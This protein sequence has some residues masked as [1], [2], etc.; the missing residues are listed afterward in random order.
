[1]KQKV[2]SS[3]GGCLLLA[4]LLFVCPIR[5]RAADMIKVTEDDN[6]VQV[7]YELT[8][9][10][11]EEEST[12]AVYR[13]EISFADEDAKPTELNIKSKVTDTEGNVYRI[14]EITDVAYKQ[15]IQTITMQDGI[16]S[17]Y[18][19]ALAAYNEETSSIKE[20]KFPST[21]E[22][23][24]GEDGFV[25]WDNH[26]DTVVVPK[27]LKN[28]T[29]DNGVVY[30]GKVAIYVPQAGNDADKPEEITLKEGCVKIAHKALFGN[31]AVKKV[32][33]PASVKTIGGAAFDGCSNLSEVNFAANAQLEDIDWRAFYDCTALTAVKIPDSVTRIGTETFSGCTS[34][35]KADISEK[36][37]LTLIEYGAFGYYP[38]EVD[39]QEGVGAYLRNLEP[40][41]GYTS[42]KNAGTKIK[43]IYLP[44]ATLH[45]YSNNFSAAGLF[46][47]CTTLEKVTIGNSGDVKAELPMEMFAGCTALKELYMNGNVK[48][49]GTGAFVDCANL[50]SVNLTGTEELKPYSFV[51]TGITEVTI[52]SSVKKVGQFSF[53]ACTELTTMNLRSSLPQQDS[54]VYLNQIIGGRWSVSQSDSTKYSGYEAVKK[55][56]PKRTAL[57]KLN[58]YMD[59][60]TGKTAIDGRNMFATALY[61]LEEVTLPEGM[62]EIPENAFSFCFSLK[63]ADF[64]ASIQK[65]GKWAF[66][67]DLNLDVDFS[68]LTNLETIEERA[69]MLQGNEGQA[70]MKEIVLPN[71]LKSIG[72]SAFY[73]Q[74]KATKVVIPESV[75]SIGYTAFQKMPS[76]QVLEI[77][78]KNTIVESYGYTYDLLS[79]QGFNS[80]FWNVGGPGTPA[81]MT[82]IV[83]GKELSET[84]KIGNGL[85]YNSSLQEADIQIDNV[86]NIGNAMFM[87]SKKLK[88]FT[89]PKTV[90][91]IDQAAF[92]GTDSLKEITIPENVTTMDVEVFRNSG[93]NKVWILNKDLIIKEPTAE[94][95]SEA[96]AK[97]KTKVYMRSDETEKDYL[98]IPKDIVIYGYAG[99]TAESYAKDYGNKFVS[100]SQVT[101]D[102]QDGKKVS[103]RLVGNGEKLTRPQDP[104]RE[105]YV[106][107]GWYTD[108]NCTTA[109][110]FETDTINKDTTLYAKWKNAFY[111]VSF[112]S[113]GGSRVLSQTVAYK[114]KVTKPEDPKREHY[115]FGGWY[116]EKGCTTEYD[117]GKE[118][119]EDAITLYAKW[120]K[121]IYTVSFESNGGS[122]VTGQQ[123]VYEGQIT[124][125]EDPKKEHYVFAGW[126][127]DKDCKTEFDFNTK[128]ES[129]ITLYAKW[130]KAIYTVSFE[131]N[132]GSQVAG[133]QIGYEGQV[134]KPEDPK[135]EHYVF[136]GWYADKNCK[137]AFH[138]KTKV[139]KNLTLYAKWN[140]KEPVI[141]KNMVISSGKYT[142]K[143]TKTSK[144]QGGTVEFSGN[145]KGKETGTV[146][147]PNTIKINGKKYKVTSIA[148]KAF[149]NNKKVKKVV[150]GNNVKTIK[151]KAFYNA[152][153][154][155]KI[156]IGANVA[157]IER[158]AFGS[159]PKLEKIIVKSKKLKK[160]H[161]K[162]FSPLK[163]KLVIK[164]YKK[165]TATGSSNKSKKTNKTS[166]AAKRQIIIKVPKSKNA[167]YEKLFKACKR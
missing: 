7:Q 75:T 59:D 151:K 4:F 64:P 77:Y 137:T 89:I 83:L 94:D 65:I 138:F 155:K 26:P 37:S 15:S 101:F 25:S 148:P 150:I 95:V 5:G 126:Y 132:G 63:K 115:V 143:V 19:Y 12:G 105:D 135:R 142:Y 33:I 162:A 104:E 109:F 164:V 9:M 69:F 18:A 17:V 10:K 111:T 45:F 44:A 61:S 124:K 56:E 163:R 118:I 86:Q 82:K 103:T 134:T 123:V 16:T 117:F 161:K 122:Q 74:E 58:V 121:E 127:T 136:A 13:A 85:F 38:Y 21:L 76:L 112:E 145:V 120:D 30:A 27:W 24:T 66:Q 159:L 87:N 43:E 98:A 152:R 47:G 153:N 88:S 40:E 133:Q 100:I 35:E 96:E 60:S 2:V 167:R 50:T 141:S 116:K 73:G 119:V 110:D 3:I 53:A 147:V 97:T 165:A 51:R 128:V 39:L 72:Y 36:S 99:S 11:S 90:K 166:A 34:L 48:T 20:M 1:M 68:G 157:T 71:S 22:D 52:P 78:G 14:K 54:S 156:T 46:A 6:G 160:V 8:P 144:N 149:A 29:P 70:A 146:T 41:Y 49:I 67:F 93:L 57:R 114:G 79:S 23:V 28:M 102:T 129:I 92:Y 62:T 84:G 131:S 113:N 108:K 80:T 42:R 139:E 130:D 154:L 31:T 91:T 125:P 106:F 158:Q 32:N 140:K 107:V 81:T 55:Q